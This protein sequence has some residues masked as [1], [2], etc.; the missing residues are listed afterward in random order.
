MFRVE[1]ISKVIPQKNDIDN[2]P[3]P[4]EETKETKET[5][6]KEKYRDIYDREGNRILFQNLSFE[7]KPGEILAVQG[8]TGV[9]KTQ[10]L[11]GLSQLSVFDKGKITLA[12]YEPRRYGMPLWRA[13]VAYVQQK[14]PSVE[15][16]PREVFKSFCGLSAQKKL[17]KKLKKSG[18]IKDNSYTWLVKYLEEIM[19]QWNL[20]PNILD[21]NWVE[22]SGGEHQRMNLAIA[23]A[24]SPDVLLMDEPTS[25]LDE[26]TTSLVEKTI[27]KRK[28]TCVWV[29]HSP[30]QADRIG[31][32]HL[33]IERGA[34][35]T[36]TRNDDKGRSYQSKKDD[37][38]AY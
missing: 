1:G 8:E 14:P 22:L 33:Y 20:D 15:G 5:K 9:G 2:T 4:D 7:L 35:H 36:L 30:T 38:R 34:K 10:I 37:E 21:Q 26:E 23:V 16:T 25:A 12:G 3:K 28:F 6:S 19:R 18:H 32:Q 31:D 29:T 27:Q 13:R 11:R 24:L 17:Q